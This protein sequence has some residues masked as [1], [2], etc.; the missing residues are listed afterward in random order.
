MVWLARAVIHAK[1]QGTCCRS[2]A[3]TPFSLSR[4]LA[5]RP[6]GG[7]RGTRQGRKTHDRSESCWGQS[8]GGREGGGRGGKV[9][10]GRGTGRRKNMQR[11]LWSQS[12][13]GGGREGASE[14]PHQAVP[15]SALL[16]AGAWPT[17]YGARADLASELGV[18]EDVEDGQGREGR[19]GRA[20]Q[21]RAVGRV[22]EKS[23]R[24]GTGKRQ[25]RPKT[26]RRMWLRGECM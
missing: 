12:V 7:W 16:N 18:S 14:F 5:D 26:R 22:D 17:W 6:S 24:R 20:G 4:Q 13:E 11:A 3:H 15:V 23:E 10:R 2:A 19:E 9:A 25:G 8:L 1:G 21:S